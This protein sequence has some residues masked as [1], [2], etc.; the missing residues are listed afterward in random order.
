MGSRDA[1]R[2]TKTEQWDSENLPKPEKTSQWDWKMDSQ[3]KV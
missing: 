3:K 1:Q 2:I